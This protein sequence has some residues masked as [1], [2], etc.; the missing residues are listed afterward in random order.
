MGRFARRTLLGGACAAS[1]ALALPA[2][3][4]AAV[5]DVSINTSLKTVTVKAATNSANTVR[6]SADVPGSLL[7]VTDTA[8]GV[9]TNDL[10]CTTP[11]PGTVACPLGAL[12]KIDVTLS[13]RDDSGTIDRSVPAKIPTSLDGGS[14]N[15]TLIGGL[16]EDALSA[17]S[18]N[19]FMD[20]G[21][22]PD[23]FRGGSGTDTVSYQSHSS[24]VAAS[25]GGHSKQDGGAED[26]APGSADTI[27]GD[28]ENVIGGPGSDLLVGDKHNNS[29][30]GLGGPDFLIGEAGHDYLAGGDGTD[31]LVGNTGNDLLDGG[32][33]P[34]ILHGNR[35]NDFLFAR[36]GVRDISLR[37]GPGLDRLRRDSIDP[38][39]RSCFPHRRHH[40]RHR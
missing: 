13:N 1:A 8:S 19:D 18:G 6:V 20:G 25:I 40:H 36:D 12:T 14:N 29:L 38:H 34:D 4:A 11:T 5:T 24:G 23:T 3:A 22:G 9:A 26:G 35:D 16:G 7:L 21:P 10:P 2:L 30:L 33:S 31:F 28:V 39:G 32:G 17:S 37:C 15:D 27:N